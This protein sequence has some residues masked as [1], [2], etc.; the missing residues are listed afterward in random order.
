MTSTRRSP[1]GTRARGPDQCHPVFPVSEVVSA[2]K[3]GQ[4][5]VVALVGDQLVGMAVAQVHGERAWISMVALDSRWRN[6]GI[7]SASAQRARSPAAHTVGVRRISAL[8]PADATGTAALAQLGLRR[9]RRP[10]ATSKSSNTS[11]RPTRVSSPRSAG[12]CSRVDSGMRWPG[13]EAEKRVIEQRI[14]LPLARA[15]CSPS[16]TAC[17]RPRRSFCSAHPAP[18]RQASP[19]PSRAVSAGRSWS[20]FRHGLPPPTSRW[21]PRYAR[22]SP[23]SWS[24]KP[25]SS[26]STR[27]K[28]SPGHRSGVV[29]DPA[30]GLTNELLK[31]IP[32]F[33]QHD[34]RLL[35]C[36]TNSCEVTGFGVPAAGAV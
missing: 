18:V 3:S 22:R 1:S 21:P 12:R 25:R 14:V 20:C 27:S 7:G 36:A 9:T 31:L 8:L 34:E 15:R 32:V 28:T 26:S 13:M 4:P 16:S 24:S 35:I 5:S 10:D 19:R 17:R 29:S 6:R 11:V 33:R 30:H 2:A 23:A